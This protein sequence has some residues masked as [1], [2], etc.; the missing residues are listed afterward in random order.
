MNLIVI[1][2]V[3]L[4]PPLA[5]FAPLLTAAPEI[6]AAVEEAVRLGKSTGALDAV[7]AQAPHLLPALEAL[8]KALFPN[9]TSGHAEAAAQALFNPDSTRWMQ[10]FLNDHGYGPL[11]VDGVYGPETQAAVTKFQ[12]ANPPLEEDG[13]CGDETWAAM[14][15]AD[16]HI[17]KMG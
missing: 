2:L 14:S 16:D 3:G 13:W 8:G 6:I 5:P 4:F 11:E 15:H 1:L 10:I 7:G 17:A 9:V 12:T